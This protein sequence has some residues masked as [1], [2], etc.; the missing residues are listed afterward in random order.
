ML[1]NWRSTWK[2]HVVVELAPAL[3]MRM[4]NV[5]VVK[6]GMALK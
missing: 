4:A 5:G 2:T 6:G 3:L 1:L